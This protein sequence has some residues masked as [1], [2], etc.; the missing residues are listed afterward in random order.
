MIKK[1]YFL[2]WLYKTFQVTITNEYPFSVPN[3]SFNIPSGKGIRLSTRITKAHEIN[4]L[5]DKV[6]YY[7]Q[8][9]YSGNSMEW[10]IPYN[11][12][13][14]IYYN[15]NVTRII[16]LLKKD[17]K[18]TNTF[19]INAIAN[20]AQAQTHYMWMW[21]ENYFVELNKLYTVNVIS[22]SPSYH[23]I[24]LTNINGYL[25]ISVT[26]DED[27]CGTISVH[28][29]KC[30]ISENKDEK[31]IHWQNMFKIGTLTIYA[32]DFQ[33]TAQKGFFLQL[34]S[35]A[36]KCSCGNITGKFLY[37]YF[38]FQPTDWYIINS[39]NKNI[40]QLVAQHAYSC[41]MA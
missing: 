23:Y 29:L 20:V 13:N 5:S 25:K 17:I 15:E 26:S 30:P 31:T 37:T 38:V 33:N 40:F 1:S 3:L 35:F 34:R 41:R 11:E 16:C 22:G 18:E 27:V 10:T 12:D 14:T 39:V 8:S 24:D 21:D 28:P 9:K 36:S 2:Q 4:L 19:T 32:K 7:I 6:T